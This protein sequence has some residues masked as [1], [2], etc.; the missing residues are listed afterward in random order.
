MRGLLVSFLVLLTGTASLPLYAADVSVPHQFV[1]GQKAVAE[2]VNE[3][4]RV[5]A[6]ALS[7]AL[8]R[9]ELLEA[10]NT[11]LTNEL[12]DI[13]DADVQLAK[14]LTDITD[15]TIWK[16]N[17]YVELLEG[18]PEVYGY[19]TVR[20]SSVN[21]QVVDGTGKTQKGRDD[22]NGLGNIVIGYNEERVGRPLCSL[23]QYRDEGECTF[24]GGE[25]VVNHKSGSHNL[26]VGQ[27]MPIL[28]PLVLLW[29]LTTSSPGLRLAWLPED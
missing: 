22:T 26:V 25:W 23:G 20:F 15:S 16:L 8:D 9:I 24:N 11:Q 4:F 12:A 14:A 1:G 29:V 7:D 18:E 5:L 19:R 2:E 21:L 17:D 10:Q 28:H 13:K 27:V 6:K 3:N